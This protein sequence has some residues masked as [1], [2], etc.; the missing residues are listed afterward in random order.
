MGG[1]IQTNNCQ[2]AFDQGLEN[3]SGPKTSRQTAIPSFSKADL[4][5]CC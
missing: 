4:S 5:I 1:H 2:F 3:F